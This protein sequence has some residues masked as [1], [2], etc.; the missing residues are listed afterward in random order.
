[1]VLCGHVGD[2]GQCHGVH[3]ACMPTPQER[4]P[5]VLALREE[6]HLWCCPWHRADE[7]PTVAYNSMAARPTELLEQWE[8]ETTILGE[9][10]GP[11]PGSAQEAANLARRL[12]EEGTVLCVRL[13]SGHLRRAW[14]EA[15]SVELIGGRVNARFQWADA[16]DVAPSGCIFGAGAYEVRVGATGVLDRPATDGRRVRPRPGMYK[17]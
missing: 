10:F 17:S 9:E 13:Q 15:G 6:A 8:R 12:A 4:E 1:M 3:L 2:G 7:S 5:A 11:G 16:S 14:L